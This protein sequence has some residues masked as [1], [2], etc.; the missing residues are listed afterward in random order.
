MKKAILMFGLV[1]GLGMSMAQAAQT[2]KVVVDSASVLDKPQPDGAVVGSVQKDT[3]IAV[4]NVAT[5]GY[6]KSRIPGGTVGWISG[7]DIQ[8]GVAGAAAPAEAAPVAEKKPEKKK[9][10]ETVSD[11][12][13]II[14]SGGLNSLTMGGFPEE[15]SNTNSKTGYGVTAEMQFKLSDQFYW[16]GRVEYLFSSSAQAVSSSVNQTLKFHTL[17]VMAGLMYVPISKSKYRVGLGVY[18]GVSLMTSMTV[19]QT[20]ALSDKTVTYTSSDFTGMANLQGSYAITSGIS[21]LGDFGYRL[22]SASYPEATDLS[23]D[24]FKANFGGLVMR[25]GVEFRL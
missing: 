3:N 24:A 23:A 12:S 13:R 11:H 18:A 6:Y 7:A 10:D 19:N 8:V 15:I 21:V 22:H 25:L 9:K 14:I 4:S 17:P 5:N 2:A 20:S 16:G 1:L